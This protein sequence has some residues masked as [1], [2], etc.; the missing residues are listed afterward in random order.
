MGRIFEL[1]YLYY[2]VIALYFLA[3]VVFR[4]RKETAKRNRLT[5]VLVGT[6]LLFFVS[7]SSNMKMRVALHALEA[8]HI[9]IEIGETINEVNAEELLEG[10]SGIYCDKENIQT[11][12]GNWKEEE[13]IALK[14]YKDNKLLI[15]V[16][17]VEMAEETGYS[18]KIHGKPM[19][20]RWDM[21]RMKYSPVF[22]ENLERVLS[23]I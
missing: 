16:K 14:F 1:P 6:L 10:V 7:L 4:W 5:L 13:T 11:L 3:Y 15:K 2:A 23:D 19:E 18:G 21:Y 8:D 17:M 9:V 22:Y 20:I 12:I